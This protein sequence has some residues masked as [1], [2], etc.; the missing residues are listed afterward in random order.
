MAHNGHLDPNREKNKS[1]RSVVVEAGVAFF[2]DIFEAWIV[3]LPATAL[4]RVTDCK[5]EQTEVI[6]RISSAESNRPSHSSVNSVLFPFGR[7]PAIKRFKMKFGQEKSE[8]ST[9]EFE[10]LWLELRR[11]FGQGYSFGS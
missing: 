8:V 11:V 5:T 4:F 1:C 3:K 9:R 10:S 7:Q 2:T 6:E